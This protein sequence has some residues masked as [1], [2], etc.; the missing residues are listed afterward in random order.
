M[1]WSFYALWAAALA[2]AIV[3]AVNTIW[4]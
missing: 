3:V 1:P 2:T 4:F